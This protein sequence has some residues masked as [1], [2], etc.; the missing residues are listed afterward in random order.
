MQS[1]STIDSTNSSSE[2]ENIASNSTTNT[3]AATEAPSDAINVSE[4]DI[5]QDPSA[6]NESSFATEFYRTISHFNDD[7]VNQAIKLM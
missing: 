3:I 4:I 7:Q 1:E 5:T 2:F 6:P